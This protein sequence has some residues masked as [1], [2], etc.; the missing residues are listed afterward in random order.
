MNR[1]QSTRVTSMLRLVL[2]VH[3]IE[4]AFKEVQSLRCVVCLQQARLCD[5]RVLPPGIAHLLSSM[6]AANLV[7]NSLSLRRSSICLAMSKCTHGSGSSSTTGLSSPMKLLT[8]CKPSLSRCFLARVTAT[9]ASIAS[10]R[11]NL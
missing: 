7:M 5:H 2:G 11:L 6:K 1:L 4:H 10:A 9:Y 3:V 8:H